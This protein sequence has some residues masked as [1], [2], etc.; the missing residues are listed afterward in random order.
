[1]KNF[2]KI[3]MNTYLFFEVKGKLMTGFV[4]LIQDNQV[5]I[6]AE[7][8]RVYV[9]DKQQFLDKGLFFSETKGGPQKSFC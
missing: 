1:M 7:N 4:K 2:S 9:V 8:R 3:R 6:E 5:M